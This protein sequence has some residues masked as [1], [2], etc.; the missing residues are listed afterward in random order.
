MTRQNS[1]GL[2]CAVF[3]TRAASGMQHQRRQVE[4]RIAERSEK[5]GR[6]RGGL[7]SANSQNPGLRARPETSRARGAAYFVGL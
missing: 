6:M 2:I 5:P 4:D 3:N 7:A 1:A